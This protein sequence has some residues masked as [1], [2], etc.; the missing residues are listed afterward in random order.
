MLYAFAFAR[1]DSAAI[2]VR[3]FSAADATRFSLLLAS[4]LYARL[5]RC[6]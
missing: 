4:A 1:F 6:C 2:T 5:L 3:R